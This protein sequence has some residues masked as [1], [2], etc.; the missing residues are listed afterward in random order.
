MCSECMKFLHSKHVSANV[1]PIVLILSA[2]ELDETVQIV[3]YELLGGRGVDGNLIGLAV[4]A[5][6]SRTAIPKDCP[7]AVGI[8]QLLPM[9]GSFSINPSWISHLFTDTAS[10]YT[11]TMPDALIL[12]A[13]SLIV[14]GPSPALPDIGSAIPDSLPLLIFRMEIMGSAHL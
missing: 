14:H 4:F 11:L 8:L 13:S 6:P 12:D 7:R 1:N 10:A 3:D 2:K 9:A 5:F